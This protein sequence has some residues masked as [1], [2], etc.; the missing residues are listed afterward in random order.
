MFANTFLWLPTIG[1]TYS[2]MYFLLVEEGN[3]LAY[4]VITTAIFAFCFYFLTI[5]F[6]VYQALIAYA[7]QTTKKPAESLPVP[8]DS[9]LYVLILKPSI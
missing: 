7:E 5:Y 1:V 9:E 8:D 6:F 2:Y 3:S 4:S